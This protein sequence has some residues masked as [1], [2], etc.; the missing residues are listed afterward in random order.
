MLRALLI[1]LPVLVLCMALQ[2][3]FVGLSLRWYGGL[4]ALVRRNRHWRYVWILSAVLMVALVGNLLQMAMWAL[5][6]LVLGE[7]PDYAS[8]LY[9]S[10]VNFTTLG[11]GD[12]VMSP[13]FRL[14]GALE[15]ANGILMFGVS[16]AMMTAAVIDLLKH[17]AKA[18]GRDAE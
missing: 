8:A 14:L 13:R 2:A 16:T 18:R 12:V 1:G 9:H 11:Y 10:A 6:F 17:E 4:R 15:A 3:V 5:L 7:F